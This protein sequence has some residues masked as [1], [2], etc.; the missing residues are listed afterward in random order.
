MISFKGG[1]DSETAEES[2]MEAWV[3][4]RKISSKAVEELL[5]ENGVLKKEDK[6][7]LK[8]LDKLVSLDRQIKELEEATKE[9]E[10]E[11]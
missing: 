7:F 5:A 4:A 9:G 11:E 6:E 3:L 10:G 8:T 2:V 1:K